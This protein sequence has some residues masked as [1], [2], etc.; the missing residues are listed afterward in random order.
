LKIKDKSE[1]GSAC[2]RVQAVAGSHLVKCSPRDAYQL[3][4][5]PPLYTVIR[6]QQSEIREI[7]TESERHGLEPMNAPKKKVQRL[8]MKVKEN[9]ENIIGCL[10]STDTH[11]SIMRVRV[12]V[13]VSV[14]ERE[15]VGPTKIMSRRK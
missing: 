12:R 13:R 1:R 3:K 15:R 5:H 4:D 6:N 11:L 2:D 7:D 14:R 8:E 10:L 9:K